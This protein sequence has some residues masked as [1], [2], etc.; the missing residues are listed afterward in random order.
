MLI[1]KQFV[2]WIEGLTTHCIRAHWQENNM[3][4]QILQENDIPLPREYWMIYRG[5]DFLAVL[6]F[7]SSPVIK[8]SLFLSLPVC[9]RSSLRR[10]RGWKGLERS[11]IIRRRESLVIYKSFNTLPLSINHF[12]FPWERFEW[13]IEDQAFSSSYDFGS[14]PPPP[15]PSP[16]I[17]LS[18]FLSL[19]VCRRSSLQTG[20]GG[21][22]G[23]RGAKLHDDEKAW[24]S[25]KYSILSASLHQFL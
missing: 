11:Q 7:G 4:Y 15:P 5:P 21:R 19:P 16:V 23:W 1:L 3:Q 6:W 17:K 14:Y 2:I 12:L 8:M 22:R 18:L 13:F 20:K 9:R 24:S 10:E 25:I